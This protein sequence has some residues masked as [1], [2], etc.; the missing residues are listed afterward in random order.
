MQLSPFTQYYIRKLIRQY[1]DNLN[2]PR[3]GVGIRTHLQTNLDQLLHQLY[4]QG[5][6]QRVKAHELSTLV[7]LHQFC[8]ASPQGTSHDDLAEIEQ[9]I[10]W[11]L[12]LKF[13]ALLPAM[14]LNLVPESSTSL[15]HFVLD[16]QMRQG[17]RYGDELYGKVLEFGQGHSPQAY[18]LLV[19]LINQQ[20]PFILTVSELRHAIWVSL[21]SPSYSVLAQPN[22]I[23]P[24]LGSLNPSFDRRAN[25]QERGVRRDL[26][27]GKPASRPVATVS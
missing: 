18:R 22:A 21:R 5:S 3:S 2:Y 14:L 19:K 23:C 20:T 15:F 10:L 9:K 7:Q 25:V 16:S 4:A 17:I 26:K 13:L 24:T 6:E 27:P 12:G 1:V 11:I 8:S